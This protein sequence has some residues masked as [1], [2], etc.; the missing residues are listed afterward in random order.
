MNGQFKGFLIQARSR[1]INGQIMNVGEF[2]YMNGN[3]SMYTVNDLKSNF[4]F[5][6]FKVHSNSRSRIRFKVVTGMVILKLSSN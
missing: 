5:R 3:V 1:N 2:R 4:N 6:H